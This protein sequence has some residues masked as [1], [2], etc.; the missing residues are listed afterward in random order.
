MTLIRAILIAAALG[1]AVGLILEAVAPA[2][3][4]GDAPLS[5][6][7]PPE[8]QR[9][10]IEVTCHDMRDCCGIDRD[11]CPGCDTSHR[12]PAPVPLPAPIYLLAS[13]MVLMRCLKGSH[14]V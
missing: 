12:E 2:H 14:R 11:C 9:T 4:A 5:D 8:W 3:A 7:V 6:I 13:A 10:V 1:F